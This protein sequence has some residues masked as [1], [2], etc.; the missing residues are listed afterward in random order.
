MNSKVDELGKIKLETLKLSKKS[1]QRTCAFWPSEGAKNAKFGSKCPKKARYPPQNGNFHLI[2]LFLWV[3]TNELSAFQIQKK[4]ERTN[5]QPS[6]F[7]KKSNER[8][9]KVDELA[10]Y[11]LQEKGWKNERPTNL[12]VFVFHLRK[13]TLEEVFVF[14][15]ELAVSLTLPA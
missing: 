5:F 6:K 15:L 14:R 12:F 13:R 3:R 2:S 4:F 1:N 9:F 11:E 7:K 10:T 8:T